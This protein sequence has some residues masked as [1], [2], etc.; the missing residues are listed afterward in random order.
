MLDKILGGIA[1]GLL[2]A[3]GVCLVMNANLR[4]DLATVKANAAML[5]GV[6]AEL[7]T[8]AEKQNRAIAVLKAESEARTRAAEKA[9]KT[10]GM[11]AKHYAAEADLIGQRPVTG[12]DDCAAATKI[13]R[14]YLAR[15][16]K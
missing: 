13:L 16:R 5:T 6:N 10:A 12:D 11:L 2:A 8:Q 3:L 4:A 1:A 15:E 9:V 14:D 7:K